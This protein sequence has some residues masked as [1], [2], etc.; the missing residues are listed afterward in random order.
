[1]FCDVQVTAECWSGEAGGPH[2]QG[3]WLGASPGSL[4]ASLQAEPAAGPVTSPVD[5][6]LN[7]QVAST[8][9]DTLAY[10]HVLGLS[11]ANSSNANAF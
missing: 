4:K 6:P 9:S 1:M 3:V 8:C 2:C 5:V 10:G 7:G 11:M